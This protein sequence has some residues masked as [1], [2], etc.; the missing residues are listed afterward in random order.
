MPLLIILF[1]CFLLWAIPFKIFLL[2]G[3]AWLLYIL[4][5]GKKRR[6]R[7]MLTYIYALEASGQPFLI[8]HDIYFEAALKFGLEHGG[9]L[10]QGVLPQYADR[11]DVPMRINGKYC[12]LGIARMPSGCAWLGIINMEDIARDF[13]QRI[14]NA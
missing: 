11:I 5:T 1:I 6:A 2:L 4:L 7:K 13:Q 3:G 8:L 12:M 14:S 9:K 10:P